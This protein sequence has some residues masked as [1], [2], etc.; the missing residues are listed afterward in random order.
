MAAPAALRKSSFAPVA[1]PRARLLILGSLP[2]EMSL[3]IGQ[4]YGNPQNQFWRLMGAALGRELPGDYAARLAALQRA[5][6][7]LWDVVRSAV[8]AG[9]LDG[10]IRDHQ[11]NP[12]ADFAA[13]LPRLQAVAFN[14]KTAAAIGARALADVAAL[15]LIALP[16][17]SPAYTLAFERKAEAWSQLAR[18]LEP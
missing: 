16:S 5:G 10:Q 11:P 6:V 4:Y 7:A 9:S 14:G 15:E 3:R 12:L 2:G 18:F 13:T 8:R 1:D 17:S